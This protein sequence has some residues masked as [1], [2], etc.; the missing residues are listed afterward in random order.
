M[1]SQQL[2]SYVSQNSPYRIKEST[3]LLEGARFTTCKATVESGETVL[4]KYYT[5]MDYDEPFHLQREIQQLSLLKDLHYTP[6]LL[7]SDIDYASN[8]GFIITSFEKGETLTPQTLSETTLLERIA[9]ALREI[10]TTPI[11]ETHL[12][13]KYG[14]EGHGLVF[15][16][17]RA[18]EKLTY[19]K[20]YIEILEN[21]MKVLSQ[22]TEPIQGVTH[23]DII[24]SN[25]LYDTET[26]T[27][28]AIIDWEF[29]GHSDIQLDIAKAELRN[30]HLF[31]DTYNYHSR[32]SSVKQA[33]NQ[34][35]SAYGEELSTQRIYA[36]KQLFC[37]RE[38]GITEKFRTESNCPQ[39]E[40]QKWRTILQNI[41]PRY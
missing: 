25:V 12:F 23:G 22:E 1:V 18:L 33:I 3:I 11:P 39:A 30:I 27:V 6:T 24:P 13:G 37:L 16:S 34:F 35:R 9:T 14:S 10:H 28:T 31:A 41:E 2:Y 19:S 20:K 32:I 5:K 4:L 17:Q 38:L 21:A 36:Y 40:L 26:N 7:A 29:S 8:R 15:D